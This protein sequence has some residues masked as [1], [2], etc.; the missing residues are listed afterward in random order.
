[1]DFSFHLQQGQQLLDKQDAVS[2]KKALEHFKKANEMIEDEHIGKP[3]TLYHLALGNYYIGQIEQSYRIA[4]KA[5]R[6][7]DTAIEN[8]IISMNNMRQ[9]LGENDIDALIQHIEEKFPQIV[10]Q[11]DAD[12]DDFDENDLDFSRLNQIYPTV[13]AEEIEPEFSIEDLDDEVLAA[14][15]FG[16]SRTN[17]ELVYFDKLKGDVLSYVQG[18]FSSLLGDQSVAN[19]RL[20]NRITNGEPTDF[21]DEERYILIDRLKLTDFLNEYKKQSNGKEPFN[22]FV[23]YFSEEILKE[24]TYDED[25]TIDDLANSNHIQKKFHKMFSEK[26]QNRVLELRED[27]SEIYQKT[28][29]SLALKWIKDKVFNKIKIDDDEL[30]KMKFTEH[31]ELIRKCAK[32]GDIKSLLTIAKY[33]F[34][35]GSAATNE[36]DFP[37]MCYYYGRLHRVEELKELLNEKQFHLF[38]LPNSCKEL[39]QNLLNI[40]LKFPH[41][42][43]QEISYLEQKYCDSKT[44]ELFDII[45]FDSDKLA[46]PIKKFDKNLLNT[47]NT[48]FSRDFLLNIFSSF[49]ENEELDSDYDE[50]YVYSRI[51]NQIIQKTYEDVGLGEYIITSPIHSNEFY[52]LLK[53]NYGAECADYCIEKLSFG[54]DLESFKTSDFY[55]LNAENIEEVANDYFQNS[56]TV[57]DLKAEIAKLWLDK[58]NSTQIRLA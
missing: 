43:E 40:G 15:Y 7:I 48:D 46:R 2:V 14:T 44:F 17:D 38:M 35:H 32:N 11:I 47:K 37:A 6:S 12:D 52:N 20:A 10:F 27:Y 29:Q 54:D 36:F 16:L 3:K 21:V 25:L 50:L 19:R 55:I 23:D 41:L 51:T 18:Y 45:M 22:S 49:S 13:D 26:Y 39:A 58:I 31:F 4:H 42:N 53:K 28:Q 34:I 5:K 1:M 24:F 8:S 57:E 30:A 56:S 9:M 33:R